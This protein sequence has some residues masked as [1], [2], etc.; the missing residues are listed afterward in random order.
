MT[1]LTIVQNA[2]NELGISEPS[3]VIGNTNQQIKQLLS[4]SNREGKTLAARPYAG[5]QALMTEATFTTVATE[6]QGTIESIAPSCKYIVRN[7]IWNRST[8]RPVIGEL[9]PTEWQMLKASP[10]SNVWDHFRIRG[11]NLL[12]DPVP[13]A[14]HTC[15]FEYM[16]KLWCESS[17][18]TAQ[19]VWADDTD[20]GKLDEE[21]M[22]LGLIWRWK[23]M[24]GFSYQEEFAEY[25]RQVSDAIARDGV[26][27][28]ISLNGTRNVFM[29]G[30]LIPSTGYGV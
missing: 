17:G 13:E 2:C 18:G 1:L 3:T 25:E 6:N 5:W 15:A 8:Q 19:A 14:G 29:S 24:K 26:K 27:P 28:T 22:T 16:S 10:V 23:S 9:Q 12:F 11:G 21:L 7:T 20:I 30:L 4:L